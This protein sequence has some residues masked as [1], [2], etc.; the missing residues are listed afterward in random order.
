MHQ[1]PIA[2]QYAGGAEGAG[3]H[4]RNGDREGDAKPA[5]SDRLRDAA[6]TVG[7]KVPARAALLHMPGGPA[8]EKGSAQQPRFWPRFQQ[9]VQHQSKDLLCF[10]IPK[11]QHRFTKQ[12]KA[13]ASIRSPAG[14]Y[15][16]ALAS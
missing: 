3:E 15:V 6:A 9:L 14:A 1:E 16:A 11:Q 12:A 10:G 7:D 4:N 5:L 13:S 8:R 2:G